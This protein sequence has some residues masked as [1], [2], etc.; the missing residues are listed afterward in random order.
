MA[1]KRPPAPRT[2]RSRTDSRSGKGIETGQKQGI[3][4]R[5]LFTPEKRQST[6]WLKRSP[7]GPSNTLE[8]RQARFKPRWLVEG[9]SC[10]GSLQPA[11][12][13]ALEPRVEFDPVL[14]IAKAVRL[15]RKAMAFECLA[16]T[17]ERVD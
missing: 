1:R 13:P 14:R 6:S 8:Q 17:L 16:V 12:H 10:N 11:V 2:G 4:W 15:A 7:A 5:R 9:D 3:A